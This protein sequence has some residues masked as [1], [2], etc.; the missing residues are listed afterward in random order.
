MVHVIKF[1]LLQENIFGKVLHHPLSLV[2]RTQV[3]A[4]IFPCL[5]DLRENFLFNADGLSH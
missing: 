3:H 1:N 4:T 2:V 5:I